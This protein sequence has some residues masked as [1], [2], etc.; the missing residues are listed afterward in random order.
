ME[1]YTDKTRLY[2]G[3]ESKCY[4]LV[5]SIGRV[6]TPKGNRISVVREEAILKFFKQRA[7]PYLLDKNM[8]TLDL[9][10][11]AQH[12]GLPTRLLDWTWNP[13]VAIYF[14]VRND[15]SSLQLGNNVCVDSKDRV[16][17]IWDKEEKGFLDLDFDPFKISNIEIFLPNYLSDRIVSQKGIFS[18]HPFPYK[19]FVSPN[20][21][22]VI[23]KNEKCKE[24]KQILNRIG[25]C[26]SLLFPDL[27]SIAT[28]VK[29]MKT[30]AF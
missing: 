10:A 12:H 9:L 17:Y 18:I 16:V 23:I 7:Y 14:A 29:W 22:R 20:I 24:I 15:N 8:K 11:L 6:M 5:P 3:V 21:V 27:D 26:E 28:H 30:D 1:K 13:L 25:I 4:K 2:R 19:P